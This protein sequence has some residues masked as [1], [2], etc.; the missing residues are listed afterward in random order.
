MSRI[1]TDCPKLSYI[2]KP[3]VRGSLDLAMLYTPQEVNGI[4][5]G[6]RLD[7]DSG[8]Y[9]LAITS[10]KLHRYTPADVCVSHCLGP[11]NEASVCVCVCLCVCVCVRVCLYA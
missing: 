11:G 1:A 10:Q 5:I 4:T 7:R 6:D 2:Y 9:L 3:K 8:C